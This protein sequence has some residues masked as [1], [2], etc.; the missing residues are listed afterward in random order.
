MKISDLLLNL[1]VI[2]SNRQVYFCF[3]NCRYKVPYIIARLICNFA[4]T[5]DDSNIFLEYDFL[6][7]NCVFNKVLLLHNGYNV[8]LEPYDIYE[9]HKL[10]L[11]LGSNRILSLIK[12]ISNCKMNKKNILHRIIS[13]KL[14]GMDISDDVDFLAE[15]FHLFS[16]SEIIQIDPDIFRL[17]LKSKYLLLPLDSD[18]GFNEFFLYNIMKRQ[19]KI[20][21]NSFKNIDL[22]NYPYL[23]IG[24][25]LYIYENHENLFSYDEF[26]DMLKKC[27]DM[28][29]KRMIDATRYYYPP[30]EIKKYVTNLIINEFPYNIIRYLP[31]DKQ[32]SRRLLKSLSHQ[33]DLVTVDVGLSSVSSAFYIEI[34]MK[35]VYVSVTHVHIS[36]TLAES[37]GTLIKGCNKNASVVLLD[38]RITNSGCAQLNYCLELFD[39]LFIKIRGLK[40]RGKSLNKATVLNHIDFSGYLA[41]PLGMHFNSR[42]K[43]KDK[44]YVF[45]N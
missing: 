16:S 1:S 2:S 32:C 21:D 33:T 41:I 44:K 14:L 12:E 19:S 36:H 35:S 38:G 11:L 9:M 23:S 15:R 37:R 3:S 27:K 18:G 22:I 13:R 42:R 4:N 17:I 26:I 45:V 31:T 29:E 6:D 7:K 10:S 8:E 28:S 24:Q 43:S 25:L 40:D 34:M 5:T 39:R 20:F 30:S